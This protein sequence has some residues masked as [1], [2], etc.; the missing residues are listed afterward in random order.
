MNIV[1]LVIIALLTLGL[2]TGVYA[3]ILRKKFLKTSV[4]ETIT[5]KTVL[6]IMVPKYNRKDARSAEQLYSSL[7]GILR[8]KEKSEDHFS[9]EMYVNPNSISFLMICNKRYKEFIENQIYAQYPDSQV[10]LVHDYVD[11]FLM[12]GKHTEIVEVGLGKDNFLP[13]K[14]FYNLQID[15]LSAITSNLGSIPANHEAFFQLVI[16]PISNSWHK[17][18]ANYLNTFKTDTEIMASKGLIV[19]SIQDKLNKPGFQFVLRIG[20]TGT[21]DIIC[22]QIVNDC[23]ASLKQFDAVELNSFSQRSSKVKSNMIKDS[24]KGQRQN[25][26]L[27]LKHKFSERFLNEFETGILNIEE[28][29]SIY[30]LPNESV[31]TPKINWANSRKL[32]MPLDLPTEN[33]RLFAV[34][35]FRSIHTPFGIKKEDRR[36]HMYVV[37]KTGAGKSVMLK[38]MIYGDILSGEGLAFID[39]HGDAVEELLNYIPE[40]RMKDVIYIDPSDTDFPVALNMLDLKEGESKE[41]LADGIVTAFKRLFGESWG[42]RLQYILTTT[43]LTLLNCQNVSLVAVQ[44][45]L[46]DENYRKFLLKQ[47]KDPFLLKFWNVEFAEMA[48][49]QKLLSDTLSPIQNKVGRFLSSSMIRNMIGQ[50]KSTVDLQEAMNSGKIILINLSQGKIGE[51]NSMLLGGMLITRL[52]TNAMQRAKM[53]ENERRDFYLYVDEFQNFSTETFVKILSEARK[54]GLNL[55]VAHQYIDQLDRNIQDAIFGNVGTMINF[56]VGPKDANRLE[57]EYTPYLTGEDLVNLERFRIVLKMTIDGTQTKPFTA[58]SLPANFNKYNLKQEIKDASRKKYAQERMV[59]ED[60]L[61]KWAGQSY[62]RNG[63]LLQRSLQKE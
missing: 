5:D 45:I 25:Q 1:P 62:D 36:R 24:I 2:T 49:N 11:S 34:T 8:N 52:Y 33:A 26:K 41:L 28:V 56:V 60:K 39:P 43:I 50:V 48:K 16:R 27:D 10:Y 23:L 29:A 35:D 19:K 53:P 4:H 55:V 40:H 9:L 7:H 37:G 20:A 51:E 14:T 61:N 31:Q 18:G 54:Y 47:V 12:D 46:T 15:P 63:N 22:G 44:R 6:K 13:I 32:E 21:S 38:N 42:P 57:K 59:V 58:I 30:H 17:A 3:L